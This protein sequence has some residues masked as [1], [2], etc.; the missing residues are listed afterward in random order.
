MTM[1]TNNVF[2]FNPRPHRAIESRM[3][4]AIRTRRD[5][6]TTQNTAVHYLP[7]TE[8]GNPH[9]DR[10][11]VYLFGNL[12]AVYWYGPGTVEVNAEMFRRHP[13]MTTAGR[14]R[15]L[16]VPARIEQERAIL[17]DFAA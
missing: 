15:A 13:T 5:W 4:D 8:T 3:V 9:G 7:D 6:V 11:E 10:A 14:L 17:G 12:I 16:G 1:Q 2:P